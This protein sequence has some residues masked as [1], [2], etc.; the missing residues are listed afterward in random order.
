ME[1]VSVWAFL[2]GLAAY[3]RYRLVQGNPRHDALRLLFFVCILGGALITETRLY[4]LL[5]K[6]RVFMDAM[7]NSRAPCKLATC[8]IAGYAM[9]AVAAI[10][11]AV[12]ISL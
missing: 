5:G 9:L 1:L 7:K 3:G 11:G 10:L 4:A 8:Y 2:L 12:I 6:R